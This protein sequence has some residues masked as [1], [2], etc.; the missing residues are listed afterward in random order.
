MVDGDFSL[1]TSRIEEASDASQG[2]ERIHPKGFKDGLQVQRLA[3]ATYNFPDDGGVVGAIGLGV[4]IPK[5]SVIEKAWI[6]N[7]TAPTSGGSA[8]LAINIASAG[9]ILAA[10]AV[11]SFTGLLAGIPVGT[12]A[13]MIQMTVE[14]EIVLT[15][16]VADLTA[17]K[18]HVYVNYSVND[19]A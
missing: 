11:A 1:N 12:T 4:T 18:F 14:K 13:T 16:A 7:V 15:V 2:G 17:G 8:T 3:R 6:V 5:G 19:S 9:D 10:L